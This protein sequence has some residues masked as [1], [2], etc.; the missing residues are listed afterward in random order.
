MCCTTIAV[1]DE[2][3]DTFHSLKSWML[4]VSAGQVAE[5]QHGRRQILI[6][7]HPAR[8]VVT[9]HVHGVFPHL[10]LPRETY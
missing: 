8:Q 7:L 5:K 1:H 9:P 10:N 3:A 2:G 6:G 4:T